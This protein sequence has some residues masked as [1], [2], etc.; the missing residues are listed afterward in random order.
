MAC[1]S[2]CLFSQMGTLTIL[3]KVRSDFTISI[4]FITTLHSGYYNV[5]QYVITPT[6]TISLCLINHFTI[7]DHFNVY[8][9]VIATTLTISMFMIVLFCTKLFCLNIY[10]HS[11]AKTTT[12]ATVSEHTIGYMQRHCST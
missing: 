10:V 11:N 12:V 4:R 9:C 3:N 1:R 2:T 7:F 8:D 6:L 5:L